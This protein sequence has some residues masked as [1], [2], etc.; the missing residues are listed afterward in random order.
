MPLLG[1]QLR[2]GDRHVNHVYLLIN[3]SVRQVFY[4]GHKLS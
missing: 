2:I 1:V 4:R 3:I